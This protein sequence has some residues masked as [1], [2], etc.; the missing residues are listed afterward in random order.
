MTRRALIACPH[1]QRDL[2]QFRPRFAELGIEIESPPVEQQLSEEYLLANIGRFDGVVAG[3]EPYTARVVERANRLK[4]IAKW[5]IGVDNIDLPAA[6]ERGIRVINTPGQLSAEVADVAIGYIIM[7]ARRLHE[8]D[9]AARR[10]DWQQI[11]GTSLAGK[12]LGVVGLGAIGRSVVRRALGHEIKVV[13]YDPYVE[14]GGDQDLPEVSMASLPE[15]LAESDF[16]S[17]HCSLT[18]E[19]RGLIGAEQF[20]L[21]RRGAFLVNTSRGQ[22][23]NESAL[24]DALDSGKVSG[25]ALDVFELEPLTLDNPLHRFSQC[26]FGSHNSSNTQ[27]AVDRI[28]ALA[29]SNLIEAL[30][31]TKG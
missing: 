4:A 18:P 7:L 12:T 14:A 19:T 6:R 9:A 25:A 30:K 29:V 15:L 17:L 3:D 2:D 23:V 16:V 31:E 11:R 5:G 26:I 13:A 8:I 20:A 28:N 21:M 10:G 24:A 22:L 27:E 1:L